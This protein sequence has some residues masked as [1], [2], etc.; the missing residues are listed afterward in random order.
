MVLAGQE[1][2]P[3]LPGP[4]Q[5]FLSITILHYTI[6]FYSSLF[7]SILFLDFDAYSILEFALIPSSSHTL[8]ARN[9]SHYN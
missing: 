2:Y 9:A 3:I 6:L 7:F 5:S 8:S 1:I 4:L